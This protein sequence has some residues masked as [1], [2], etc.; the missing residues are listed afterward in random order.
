MTFYMYILAAVLLL[1]ATA[2]DR[3]GPKAKRRQQAEDASPPGQAER[4]LAV[5]SPAFTIAGV[6]LVVAAFLLD[7]VLGS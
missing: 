4:V 6:L 5:V 2:I 1:A 3:F 7:H